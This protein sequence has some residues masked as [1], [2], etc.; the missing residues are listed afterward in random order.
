MQMVAGAK[1]GKAEA[2]AKNFQIYA[3]KVRGVVTHIAATQLALIE[4][5]N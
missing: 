1:L 4:D 3:S 5:G 2:T